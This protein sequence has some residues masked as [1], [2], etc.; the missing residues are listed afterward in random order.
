MFERAEYANWPIIIKQFRCFRS[1]KLLIIIIN[2]TFMINKRGYEAS[3]DKKLCKITQIVCFKKLFRA[4]KKSKY[5][6]K[7]RP[8]NW[9]HS[10]QIKRLAIGSSGSSSSLLTTGSNIWTHRTRDHLGPLPAGQ[11][12]LLTTL[13]DCH[14][15]GI[16]A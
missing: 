4:T 6:S 1:F 15:N 11:S 2:T 9:L 7:R 13:Y 16:I 3:L 5:L 12:Y 8:T 14:V 10:Y